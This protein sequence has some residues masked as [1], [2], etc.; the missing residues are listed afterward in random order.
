MTLKENSGRRGS[1]IEG[2]AGSLLQSSWDP[3][4]QD[5]HKTHVRGMTKAELMGIVTD[6]I[7]GIWG[8]GGGPGAAEVDAGVELG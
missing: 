6:C 8:R 7:W 3:R 1:G 4:T 5:G 2:P